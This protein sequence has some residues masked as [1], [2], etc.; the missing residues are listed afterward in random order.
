MSIIGILGGT[1]DPVHNGHIHVAQQILDRLELDQV[2]FLPCAI[3]VHRSVPLESAAERMRMI[4]LALEGLEKF[5]PNSLE[6]K[7]GGKS[8]MVDTLRDIRA[9][10]PGR[11]IC[12]ILG[13]D[14]FN[15]LGGWKSP[16]EILHLAHL[17]VCQRPGIELDR[18]IFSDHWVESPAML[19]NSI[20][21][22]ILPL[23]IDENPCSSTKIRNMLEVRKSGVQCLHPAVFEYIQDH[24]LYS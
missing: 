1:F 14:A 2:H 19:A 9:E 10:Y 17:V 4:E 6:L 8:Y 11:T 5:Q 3:P 22:S 12:L 24:H 20:E 18:A 16:R 21:G 23:D 13:A 7:R 15:Q